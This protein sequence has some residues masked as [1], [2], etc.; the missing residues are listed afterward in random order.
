MSAQQ[1]VKQ[2]L[3]VEMGTD[4]ANLIGDLE[5]VQGL[6]QDMADPTK[7]PTTG[8]A[9]AASMPGGYLSSPLWSRYQGF[10][11]KLAHK[12]FGT[13]LSANESER[14]ARQYPSPASYILDPKGFFEKLKNANKE[15]SR[16]LKLQTSIHARNYDIGPEIMDP[17]NRLTDT[18][19]EGQPVRTTGAKGTFRIPEGREQEAR[20]MKADIRARGG[21]DADV[22]K[23]WAKEFGWKDFFVK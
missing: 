17:V 23:A 1:S 15:M 19:E 13:A 4:Y 14:L 18:E 3:P 5:S 10:I 6:I 16:S 22:M 21:T 2:R 20:Q 12:Q 11:N 9:L 8:S 7:T